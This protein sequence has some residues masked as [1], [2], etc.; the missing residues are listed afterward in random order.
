MKIRSLCLIA[1]QILTFQAG[2]VTFLT[3]FSSP[4]Q[5]DTAVYND[6]TTFEQWGIPFTTGAG[7]GEGFTL[8]R[9]KLVLQQTSGTSPLSVAIYLADGN[10][11]PTGAALSSNFTW[12][13]I[14]T[15]GFG[16]V[17]FTPGSTLS[18]LANTTYVFTLSTGAGGD[19]L[20]QTTTDS[21]YTAT[22]GWSFPQPFVMGWLTNQFGQ[23]VWTDGGGG[24]YHFMGAI[25]ATA[26]PEPSAVAFCLG[27][28]GVAALFRCSRPARLL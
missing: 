27:G 28:F 8:D 11:V 21:N 24:T 9:I 7:T 15:A 23:P 19:Y 4:P 10:N 14:P 5:S 25:D 18:L 1:L 13:A 16:E 2:A 12:G 22:G 17:I 3:T 20:W 6:G 26:I